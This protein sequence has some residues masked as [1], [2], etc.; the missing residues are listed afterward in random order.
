VR[1]PPWIW[2]IAHDQHALFPISKLLPSPWDL[3][4]VIAAKIHERSPSH[5]PRH[6][7]YS[8]TPL[9]L[10]PLTLTPLTVTLTPLKLT[11]PL[12]AENHLDLARRPPRHHPQA[13][14]PAL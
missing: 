13:S 1:A 3:V 14:P 12:S 4:Q 11:P 6:D 7:A 9:K 10:A 5:A 2:E 8:N